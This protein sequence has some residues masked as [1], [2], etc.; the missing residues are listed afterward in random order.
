MALW[1]LL[2]SLPFGVPL[3]PKRV[4]RISPIAAMW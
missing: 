1:L 2:Y 4:W 3:L